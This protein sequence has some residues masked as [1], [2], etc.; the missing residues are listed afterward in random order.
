MKR[1][2]ILLA[3]TVTALTFFGL[4][5][6][7][8]S[9]SV[10][11]YELFGDKYGYF[12]DQVLWIIL[13]Y[14]GLAFFYF[15]DYK[16][17]F[18][19][20]LPLL[21]VSLVL[22]ILVFIPGAGSSAKGAARWINI[23]GFRLQPS[24]FV[25]LAL[26]IYLAAWFS[27]K[28]KNRF[29]AFSLLLGSVILLVMLQPDMGTASIILFEAVA[30]YFFS[31][32][33]MFHFILGAPVAAFVGFLLIKAEPYRMSRLTSFLNLGNSF[34]DTSYHTKQILIA[35]GSGGI[36][37][38]GIG[39][40]LQKY[41]YLPENVTDSIFP[42]IAEEFGFVGATALIIVFAFLIYCGFKISAN[43]R[44]SFGKLLA[45]G[46]I[47]FIGIQIVIN[48]GAMTALLPLTGVPLPFISYG[49]SALILNLASVGILLN[50]AKQSD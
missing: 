46:I 45:A 48:L 10:I 42:I 30:M 22:L 8:N 44:D 9:S 28:E 23:F 21:I 6:I 11:A 37:G 19:L 3:G 47:T 18:N 26:A 32:G 15:F 13:G 17:L 27:T 36:W 38:L 5:M 16:K 29:L 41:A 40:S 2:D 49:G 39:N 35:L 43:C 50:I 1:F 7:F 24:E 34:R 4:L 14:I 12:K 31:G 33:N 20:A 25:K